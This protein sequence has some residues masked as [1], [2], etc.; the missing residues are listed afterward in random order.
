MS[1]RANGTS[2]KGFMHSEQGVLKVG[3]KFCH[4]PFR[5]LLL[6]V[7]IF[8]SVFKLFATDNFNSFVGSAANTAGGSDGGGGLTHEPRHIPFGGRFHSS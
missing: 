7:I 3:V 5:N 1:L 4:F 8:E 6:P 2:I